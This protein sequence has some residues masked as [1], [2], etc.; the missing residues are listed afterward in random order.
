MPPTEAFPAQHAGNVCQARA[1]RDPQGALLASLI[2]GPPA[3]RV[4]SCHGQEDGRRTEELGTASSECFGRERTLQQHLDWLYRGDDDRGVEL[5]D[6][7]PNRSGGDGD[8]R[9]EPK[10]ETL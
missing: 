10:D 9:R 6:R 1:E 2:G 3:N 7:V 4:E 5:P 8:A